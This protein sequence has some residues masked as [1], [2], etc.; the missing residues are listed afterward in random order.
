MRVFSVHERPILTYNGAFY[1]PYL[2]VITKYFKLAD[3][4]SYGVSDFVEISKERAERLEKIINPHIKFIKLHRINTLNGLLFNNLENLKL[5]EDEILRSDI[6]VGRIPSFTGFQAAKI[7]KKL[8]KPFMAEAIGCAWDGYWNYNL[9]GKFLA[10]FMYLRMKKVIK[11]SSHTLYVTDKFLQRRYPCDGETI[12]CSNVSISQNSAE[13]LDRR[14]LKIQK[15]DIHS[16]INLATAA[17]IDNPLKGHMDVMSAIEKLNKHGFKFHYHI[18]GGGDQSRLQQYSTKLNIN[19]YVHFVGRLSQKDT[20]EYM[21]K[22]DIYILPSKQEGLP[23]SLIEAMHQACPAFGSKV[24]GIPELL[25]EE[26]LFHKGNYK[27]IIK[28]LSGITKEKLTKYA[29]ENF[30]KSQNYVREVLEKRRSDFFDSFLKFYNL[31]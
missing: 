19:K 26:C 18:I 11:N 24:A 28:L 5:L 22:I 15:L 21:N 29:I 3:D 27:E 6:V 31:K 8:N 30:Q 10:P 9:K 16:S 25:P 4:I 2:N 17:A 13:V 23:R 14:I 12:G 20:I 7:C 1:H